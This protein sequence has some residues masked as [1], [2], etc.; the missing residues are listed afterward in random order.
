MPDSPMPGGMLGHIRFDSPLTGASEFFNN[1]SA[2]PN[3]ASEAVLKKVVNGHTST[4]VAFNE[5]LDGGVVDVGRGAIRYMS[6]VSSGGAL[7]GRQLYSLDK[8]YD[9]RIESDMVLDPGFPEGLIIPQGL[10]ISTGLV[11]LAPSLQTTRGIGGGVDRAGSLFPGDLLLGRL[12]DYDFDG[13][14]DGV[15]VG[16]ANVPIDHLF[17]PG[18]PVAQSR[19]FAS[20]IAVSAYDAAFLTLTSLHNLAKVWERGCT[21][22]RSKDACANAPRGASATFLG[23]I[24]E[25]LRGASRHLAQADAAGGNLASARSRI[26]E[27]SGQWRH[28]PLPKVSEALSNPSAHLRQFLATL[29]DD[30]GHISAELEPHSS[31][32]HTLPGSRSHAN[33]S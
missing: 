8:E 24:G 23:D 21:G 3:I 17:S 19:R 4:G 6:V 30:S 28:F 20:D 12:G 2:P 18:C 27:L 22:A 33:S 25:R 1:G 31:F 9:W 26:S 16:S 11:S 10:V 29:F 5:Y 7:K 14:L 13:Y 15:I 32:A